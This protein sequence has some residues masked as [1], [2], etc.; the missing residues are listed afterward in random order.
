MGQFHAGA[1]VLD[2]VKKT[3]LF[4]LFLFPL[5]SQVVIVDGSFCGTSPPGRYSLHRHQVQA[6]SDAGVLSVAL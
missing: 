1:D 2:W 5:T 6:Y 3:T 4:P